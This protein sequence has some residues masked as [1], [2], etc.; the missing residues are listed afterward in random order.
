VGATPPATACQQGGCESPVRTVRSRP[1]AAAAMTY[2]RSSLPCWCWSC[3]LLKSRPL[4]ALR[5]LWPNWLSYAV[6]YPSSAIVWINHR[7]LPRF[8]A[9]S[10]PRSLWFK[11]AHLFATSLLPLASLKATTAHERP[12]DHDVVFVRRGVP[13]GA[14]ILAGRTGDLY[15]PLDR[16]SEAGACAAGS[17]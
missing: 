13:G 6:S 16:S 14:E 17:S 7:Y 12:A 11:F 2:S 9:Q 1:A 8:A 4:K 3:D 5:L 15:W 10:T